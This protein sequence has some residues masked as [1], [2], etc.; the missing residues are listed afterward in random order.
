[1]AARST[2]TVAS[3]QTITS[4]WGNSVRDHVVTR[5]TADD[6]ASEGML[7][8]NTSTKRL[9]VH[10]GAAARRFLNYSASGRTY[11][12]R[13]NT[14]GGIGA[15][16][17]AQV[18]FP[19]VTSDADGFYLAWNG[20][21]YIFTVPANLGG[22][23]SIS[24]TMSTGGVAISYGIIGLWTSTTGQVNTYA[25]GIAGCHTVVCP[26]NA[27]DVFYVEQSNGH[28]SSVTFSH[29]IFVTRLCL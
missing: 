10:D 15:G 3:G 9:M 14:G 21:H 28:S 5:T 12:D 17:T 8:M 6:A 4:S 18:L 11:C 22:L 26:L 1:M 25:A 13:S 19:T 27:G 20:S 2:F 7:S 23:Y 24:V 16:I 29:R